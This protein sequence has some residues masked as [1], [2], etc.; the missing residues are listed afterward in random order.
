MRSFAFAAA[1]SLVAIPA[2]AED[3]VFTFINNSSVSITEFYIT[4][5]SADDWGDSILVDGTVDAGTQAEVTIADGETTCD[6]D[7]RFV[8]DTGAIHEVNQNICELGTYTLTD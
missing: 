7:M 6:Y 1:L 2:F 5:H 8:A 3:V 4:K